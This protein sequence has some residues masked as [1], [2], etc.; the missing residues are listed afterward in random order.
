MSD[1][2]AIRTLTK[3]AISLAAYILS[4]FWFTFSIWRANELVVCAM[5]YYGPKSDA[6]DER[7]CKWNAVLIC[8]LPSWE[9]STD[10]DSEKKLLNFMAFF[11]LNVC[12]LNLKNVL[13]EPFGWQKRIKKHTFLSRILDSLSLSPMFSTYDRKRIYL[14]NRTVY[15][16]YV[17]RLS[18][19]SNTSF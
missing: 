17:S 1:R 6:N 7:A 16:H 10:G 5:T 19:W 8:I 18:S 11:C 12:R 3:N 14:Q 4:P 9:F 13:F 15:I 2:A